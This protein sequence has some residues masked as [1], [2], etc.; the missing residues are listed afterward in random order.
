M[1]AY[2]GF[3]ALFFKLFHPSIPYVLT[4]Q[5]GDPAHH[6]RRKVRFVHP[7]WRLIFI[8]ANSIQAISTYLASFAHDVGYIKEVEVIP[9]GVDLTLFCK[10]CRPYETGHMKNKLGKKTYLSQ[11][12][13]VH[14]VDDVFLVTASRLVPKNGIED[15]I[16]SLI[17]LPKHI[18]LIVIGDGPLML[19]LKFVVEEKNLAERVTF[20][21]LIPH[22]ELPAYFDI[23]D[24]FI[25]PSLSEGFGNS[26]IEAM[27]MKIPV[28]ATPV[29]GITD[30]VFDPYQNPN[31]EPTGI[32]CAVN[33]P[34]SIAYSVR[35]LLSDKKT[36]DRIISNAH[37]MVEEKYDW[38][39]IAQDMN[40]RVFKKVLG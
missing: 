30:F 12:D 38:N 33:N 18:S 11:S 37:K 8:K 2:A 19:R 14:T 13:D 35:L 24:I 4:L 31:R 27:A 16:N 7:L 20:L 39:L 9:N 3:G 5:E 26:F 36:H 23:C 10:D 15:I 34:K 6:I 1:A 25:R 21:G 29:G 28:I 40:E 32:F 22:E 17:Y